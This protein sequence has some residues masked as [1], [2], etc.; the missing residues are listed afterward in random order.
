MHGKRELFH[1]GNFIFK[2]RSDKLSPRARR[3]GHVR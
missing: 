3:D 1:E 2:G